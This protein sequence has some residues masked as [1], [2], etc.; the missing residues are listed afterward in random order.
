[1]SIVQPTSAQAKLIGALCNDIVTH[2]STSPLLINVSACPGAGK[3]T[4]A[5]F[6]TERFFGLSYSVIHVSEDD[7][8]QP[9][10]YR[11][12][13]HTKVYTSGEW[14]GRTY[15]ENHRNW[16]RL[17]EMKEA[18]LHLKGKKAY[19]YHPYLR[20]TGTLAKEEKIVHPADIVVFETS[21]F[22]E[23]FDVVVLIDVADSVL[24]KRK[25][26]LETDLQEEEV[27]RAYH[28]VQF[29]YWQKYKP[30]DPL[31]IINN[32]N[33]EAPKLYINRDR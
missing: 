33:Y 22:S 3:S 16:L 28:K 13:L 24:L 23:L 17:D 1:M 4:W 20:E 7:F 8:L 6:I 5:R 27:I 26:H 10:D 25:L 31:Y 14:K 19:R 11:S 15:W 32:N 21:I 18:I 9:R 29:E 2:A 12:Q 30:V